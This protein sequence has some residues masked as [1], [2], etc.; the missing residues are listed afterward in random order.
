MGNGRLTIT[1]REGDEA[2]IQCGDDTLAIVC[3]KVD[4]IA[5]VT[6]LVDATLS[7][8]TVHDSKS[9]YG[10]TKVTLRAN[11]KFEIFPPFEQTRIELFV[12]RIDL[13]KVALSIEC[14]RQWRISRLER[15]A[16]AHNNTKAAANMLRKTS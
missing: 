15:E 6:L 4:L 13:G 2:L 1:L 8:C 14:P 3:E 16:V 12:A 5:G 9:A 7:F 10:D 11:Q